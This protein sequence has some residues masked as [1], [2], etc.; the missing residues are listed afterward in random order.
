MEMGMKTA[1]DDLHWFAK[2]STCHLRKS[3]STCHRCHWLPQRM[4]AHQL[5]WAERFTNSSNLNK[6]FFFY[7]Y[8][9]DIRPVGYSDLNLQSNVYFVLAGPC[10]SCNEFDQFSFSKCLTPGFWAISFWYMHALLINVFFWLPEP[11]AWNKCFFWTH[12][13]CHCCASVLI[14][15][16][17]YPMT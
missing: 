1:E 7:M 6:L 3:V 10:E 14:P 2:A 11:V 15:A 9:K 4:V 5:A 12:R 17:Q 16:I 13:H 8:K